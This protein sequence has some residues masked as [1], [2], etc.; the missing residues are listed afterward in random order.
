MKEN[1]ADRKDGK[2]DEKH[3]EGT[4]TP[5]KKSVAN[6]VGGKWSFA[7]T[8]RMAHSSMNGRLR[9]RGSGPV[10]CHESIR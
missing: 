6:G 4:Q 2:D 9:R 5:A 7:W 8:R 1:V 3:E 10:V